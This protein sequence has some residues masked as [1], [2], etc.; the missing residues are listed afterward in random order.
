M[1]R[2]RAD[3]MPAVAEPDSPNGL[4]TATTQSPTRGGLSANVTNGNAFSESTLISAKSVFWSVPITL[5]VKVL[6]S[7]VWTWTLVA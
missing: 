2:P 6:P 4:P 5:A 1:S 3:T 7:S